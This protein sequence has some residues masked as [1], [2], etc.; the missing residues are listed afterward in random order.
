MN[1]NQSIANQKKRLTIT[2][3]D[4]G[5][6]TKM[7]ILKHDSWAMTDNEKCRNFFFGPHYK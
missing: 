5:R 1:G 4:I 3:I 6:E 7:T 2:H